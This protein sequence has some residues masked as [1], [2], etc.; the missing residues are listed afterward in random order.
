[1]AFPIIGELVVLSQTA[2]QKAALIFR[3][4]TGTLC[5]GVVD[6]EDEGAGN[7][8]AAAVVDDRI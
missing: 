6:V 8:M 2:H 4:G 7:G 5:S 1:M 3:S